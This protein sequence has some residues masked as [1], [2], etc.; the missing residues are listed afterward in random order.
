MR[1]I[2]AC[3]IFILC[4][5][6]SPPLDEE[7]FTD[8]DLVGR[9]TT[10]D[11]G[12]GPGP[13]ETGVGPRRC[14]PGERLGLCEQCS[15]TGVPE[16]AFDDGNCP[17]IDCG[18]IGQK[19]LVE[20][21][22]N[23]VCY[24]NGSAPSLDGNCIG[25]GQCATLE[26]YCGDPE[27]RKLLETPTDPCVQIVGCQGMQTP[28]LQFQPIGTPCNRGGECE[29]D[30][31]GGARCSLR[32]PSACRPEGSPAAKIFCESGTEYNKTYCE[33]FVEPPN[34]GR[35]RCVDFCADLGLEICD[36]SQGQACCWNNADAN[37]C[38][39][40]EGI[41][42]SGRPCMN[43]QGCTDMICRCYIPE[44]PQN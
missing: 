43:D 33:F 17:P 35:T 7:A 41:T 10:K 30:G 25:I 39:K 40:L 34:G 32:I 2:R 37:T 27:R 4:S 24:Q 13:S 8:G 14:N 19:E 23:T 3:L 9:I 31:N 18:A 22:D 29:A 12:V 28:T 20:E 11:R 36:S 42:C 44:A 15:A 21:G 26:D 16:V 5:C 1:Y 38:E 6:T